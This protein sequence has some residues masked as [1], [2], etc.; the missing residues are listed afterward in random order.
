MHDIDYVRFSGDVDKVIESDYR[1]ISQADNSLQGLLM[2]IGLVGRIMTGL[3]FDKVD[4]IDPNL[5]HAIGERLREEVKRNPEFINTFAK[6][7][8]DLSDW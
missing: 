3:R 6:Y 1:A 4:G 8:I 5:V 2:K 7:N